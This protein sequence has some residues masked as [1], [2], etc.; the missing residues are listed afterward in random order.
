M[1]DHATG[2]NAPPGDGMPSTL[3][4]HL[5]P[6]FGIVFATPLFVALNNLQELAVSPLTLAAGAALATLALTAATLGLSSIG[7]KRMRWWLNRILV[8][9]AIAAAIQGNFV[10]GLFDYGAFNGETMDLRAEGRLFWAEWI[11]W[12]LIPV[13]VFLATLRLKSMPPW[14]PSLPLLSFLVLLLPALW[15][16]DATTSVEE[17]GVDP[18]VF[19]FSTRGNL[20]HL[21][22]DGFQSDI[23]QEVLESNPELADRFQGFTLFTD[24]L[25]LY[26]GTAPAL[27]T[28]FT[29]AP[30]DLGQGFSE[31]MVAQA[32]KEHAYTKLLA[33]A[34]YRMDFV[35]ISSTV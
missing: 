29:G 5:S 26:Q 32:L 4:C 14:L 19:A 9:L 23:V 34:G 12:L 11:A 33:Q 16:F 3:L 15:K 30:Y 24:H 21:L 17:S 18:D 10:H 28:L 2:R 1:N 13:A 27:Y 25:G 7:G 31:A 35:P 20:I 6:W 22:P 8:T